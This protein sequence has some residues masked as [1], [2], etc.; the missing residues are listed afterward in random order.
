MSK[1]HNDKDEAI[2]FDDD[3][4]EFE[5]SGLTYDVSLDDMPSDYDD[6]EDEEEA[7]WN[8]RQYD[9]SQSRLKWSSGGSKRRRDFADSWDD[10]DW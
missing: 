6:D 1:L 7:L 2:N 10:D 8:G 5:F 9:Q 3:D 4:D